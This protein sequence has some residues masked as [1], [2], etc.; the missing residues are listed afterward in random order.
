[1]PHLGHVPAC[2][3]LPP[4]RRRKIR[5]FLKDSADL[6]KGKRHR[7]KMALAE[8]IKKC[9][10][11]QNTNPG[12]PGPASEQAALL[13]SGSYFYVRTVCGSED[14]TSSISCSGSKF[15]LCRRWPVTDQAPLPEPA[16]IKGFRTLHV[17]G[18]LWCDRTP[19][20]SAQAWWE[21]VK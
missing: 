4:P 9:E 11:E 14:C 3:L 8:G 15:S 18:K 6:Q 19:D 13:L 17:S 1:M 21:A 2:L 5:H 16:T 10:T 7:L 12:Q 20:E